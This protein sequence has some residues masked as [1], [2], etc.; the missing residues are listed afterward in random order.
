M[1]RPN[2]KW[3]PNWHGV[4]DVTAVIFDA[5]KTKAPTSTPDNNVKIPAALARRIF[6]MFDLAA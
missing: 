5:V 4:L 3:P 1:R 6:A 2:K